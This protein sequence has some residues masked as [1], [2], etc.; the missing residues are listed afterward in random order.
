MQPRPDISSKQQEYAL[1]RGS[2]IETEGSF[3]GALAGDGRPLLMLT[4]LALILSGAFALFLSATGSFLPHDVDFL[5]M[6]ARDLCGINQCRIVH[7]MIHDRVAF[8]GVLIAIGIL[9]LWLAAFPLRHGHAWSWWTFTVSG[10]VG[11]GS[12]LSYLGYGYLDTWHGAATLVLLPLYLLGMH[13]SRR[14]CVIGET[15]RGIDS[16]VRISYP[17]RQ[18]WGTRAWWGRL[19]LFLTAAGQIGGGLFIMAMGMTVVFVPQDLAYMGM[20]GAQLNIVNP[21]LIPLIAHDRAGFGGGLACIGITLALIL[22][23]ARP[24]RHLW[25]ALLLAGTVGFSCA[26]LVHFSVGYTDFVH[27]LP[28]YAG[29]LSFTVGM[30]LSHSSMHRSQL[31]SSGSTMSS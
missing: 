8:A 15:G 28:G 5:S 29:A 20:S 1:V 12:F 6:S 31:V 17:W 9:Y 25:Q 18:E 26:I 13:L 10:V 22:C 3:L 21:R 7:F 4:G 24:S 16:L 11:F 19:F 23:H 14:S 30:W 2:H 27:L